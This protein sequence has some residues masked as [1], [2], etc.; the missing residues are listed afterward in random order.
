M[1]DERASPPTSE[2]TGLCLHYFLALRSIALAV[3][4]LVLFFAARRYEADLPWASLAIAG[5]VMGAYTVHSWRALRAREEI[6]A[7]GPSARRP[8]PRAE[9]YQMD[10]RGAS[11][12]QRRNRDAQQIYSQALTTRGGPRCSSGS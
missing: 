12:G 9:T 11:T 2:L 6:V 5:L 7:S 10:R 4:L 8:L 3:H 1:H